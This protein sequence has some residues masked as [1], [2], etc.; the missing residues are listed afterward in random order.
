MHSSVS[1]S[2]LLP[3]GEERELSQRLLLGENT[4]L[5]NPQAKL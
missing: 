2:F 1:F 3:P 4:D 5:S